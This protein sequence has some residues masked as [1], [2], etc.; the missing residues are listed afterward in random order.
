MH[1]PRKYTKCT[2]HLEKNANPADTLYHYTDWSGLKGILEKQQLWL[3]LH[4]QLNDT[5]EIHHALTTIR[6]FIFSIIAKRPYTA[7]LDVVI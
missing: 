6:D 2:E 4:S 1:L 5:S 7:I 3:T